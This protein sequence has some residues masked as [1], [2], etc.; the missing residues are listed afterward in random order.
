MVSRSCRKQCQVALRARWELMIH[1][2][3]SASTATTISTSITPSPRGRDGCGARFV[4]WRT[5][6][7]SEP[8]YAEAIVERSTP[9]SRPSRDVARRALGVLSTAALI[10]IGASGCHIDR[11][12]AAFD[13]SPAADAATAADAVVCGGCTPVPACADDGGPPDPYPECACG[14]VEGDTYPPW[15]GNCTSD[16]GCVCNEH[17][18]WVPRTG[19]AGVSDA[20]ADADATAPGALDPATH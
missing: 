19:D 8:C 11:S 15:V 16:A 10:L 7:A 12:D 18:C 13:A 20:G 17:S 2:A 4:L 5:S 6:S 14:C 3:P 9:A 1:R